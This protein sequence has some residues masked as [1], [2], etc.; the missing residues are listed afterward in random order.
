MF[1]DFHA[2]RSLSQNARYGCQVDRSFCCTLFDL[3]VD[4]RSCSN[5]GC[6]LVCCGSAALESTE[7]M[8][9]WI[10]INS[11]ACFVQISNWGTIGAN[12]LCRLHFCSPLWLCCCLW[13]FR[14]KSMWRHTQ[15][16]RISFS[17]FL[18]IGVIY[19]LEI[20]FSCLVFS[21]FLCVA[22]V[23]GK[24]LAQPACH[25]TSE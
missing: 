11:R 9:E 8:H 1:T 4:C 20:T 17:F 24:R 19:V 12:T 23:E 16:I 14:E 18:Y 25:H 22:L 3:F 21:L 5:T 7:N 10:D 15:C 13:E 6:S 2:H